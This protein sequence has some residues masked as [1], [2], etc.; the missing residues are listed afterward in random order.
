[1]RPD[2]MSLPAVQ[3]V[4]KTIAKEKVYREGIIYFRTAAYVKILAGQF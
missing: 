1:M 4:R 2:K 3:H